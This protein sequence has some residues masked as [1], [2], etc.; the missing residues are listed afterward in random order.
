MGADVVVEDL[1]EIGDDGGVRDERLGIEARGR[2]GLRRLQ[3]PEPARPGDE[4]GRQGPERGVGAGDLHG[5]RIITFS[6]H[7]G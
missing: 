3:P 6:D 2:R 1:A 7:D 5:R 4:I